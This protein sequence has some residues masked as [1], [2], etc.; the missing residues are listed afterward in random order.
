MREFF[1]KQLKPK[2]TALI[3]VQDDI[4]RAINND[5]LRDTAPTGSLTTVE[6]KSVGTFPVILLNLETPPLPP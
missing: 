2:F 5:S 4:L 1:R 3:K 6:V